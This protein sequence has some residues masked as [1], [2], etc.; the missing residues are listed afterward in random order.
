[1]YKKTINVVITG[2]TGYVGLELIKYLTKHSKVKIVA[3][4][5]ENNSGKHINYFDKISL[6]P[7]AMIQVDLNLSQN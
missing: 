7:P 4:C 3:L 6:Q 5:S 2:A 1:M